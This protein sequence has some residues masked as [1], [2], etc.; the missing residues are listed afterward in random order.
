M[1]LSQMLGIEMPQ[2]IPSPP[3]SPSPL[4]PSSKLSSKRAEQVATAACVPPW[5]QNH[6]ADEGQKPQDCPKHL[7]PAPLSCQSVH[8]SETTSAQEGLSPRLCWGRVMGRAQLP[9]LT[10]LCACMFWLSLLWFLPPHAPLPPAERRCSRDW[11]CKHD[12]PDNL[13]WWKKSSMG[14]KWLEP[15]KFVS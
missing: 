14:L 6:L 1:L 3:S 13:L 10:L 9:W 4:L 12:N 8:I 11:K 5:I 7:R 2:G 15:L